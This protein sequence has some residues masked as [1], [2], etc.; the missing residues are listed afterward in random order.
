MMFVTEHQKKQNK[1]IKK[2]LKTFKTT[3]VNIEDFNQ[4]EKELWTISKVWYYKLYKFFYNKK[5][6]IMSYWFPKPIV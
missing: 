6:M 2:L 1:V 3:N 5:Y 4:L